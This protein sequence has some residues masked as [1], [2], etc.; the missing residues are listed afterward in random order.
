[1]ITLDLESA[2]AS[3]R[4]IQRRLEAITNIMDHA[5][6]LMQHWRVLMEQ[7]NLDGVLAGTD[8]DGNPMLPVTYRPRN[9]RQMTLGERLGQRVNKKRGR[10]AGVGSYAEHGIL[11][12][13]NL[14]S[15]AYRQLTGPPLAP[16]GQFSRVVTNFVTTTF[17]TETHG[18][19]VVIGTW[20]DV[21]SPTGFHFLPALFETRDLRGVRPD[22][23]EKMRATILPWAKLVVR[24]LWNSTD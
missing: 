21:M 11:P 10:L 7:G 8:G 5:E 3:C 18:D 4:R 22:D 13:N 12:N 17:Q 15:S 2:V 14:S 24:R 19:W 20:K 9:P 6:D 23:L 1:M 16:R